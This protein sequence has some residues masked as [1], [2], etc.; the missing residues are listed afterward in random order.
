VD[1][2]VI[3]KGLF[4]DDDLKHRCNDSIGEDACSNL[5]GEIGVAA[6]K[7]VETKRRAVWRGFCCCYP[8]IST[9]TLS[10]RIENSV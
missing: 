8:H 1:T 7:F 4:V 6:E 5:E 2:K 9:T 10:D 3:R